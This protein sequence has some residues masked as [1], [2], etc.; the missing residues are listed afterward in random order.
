MIFTGLLLSGC[1]PKIPSK[2][3]SGIQVTDISGGHQLGKVFLPDTERFTRQKKHL[4][5]NKD[6]LVINNQVVDKMI[7]EEYGQILQDVTLW[8]SASSPAELSRLDAWL[9]NICQAF[10]TGLTIV[11]PQPLRSS[12]S[13]LI[14]YKRVDKACAALQGEVSISI[15]YET[16]VGDDVTQGDAK[17]Y[18]RNEN[19]RPQD[20]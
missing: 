9:S 3:T 19:N 17:I 8:V 14:R 15:Q 13:S 7:L 20:I 1:L 6:P 11:K 16:R 2:K 18:L 12:R 4:Y 5:R 10:G